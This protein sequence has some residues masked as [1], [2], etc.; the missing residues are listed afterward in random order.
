MVAEHLETCR[1][2]GLEAS[3]YTA[4]KTAITASGPDGAPVD[5]EAVQRLRQFARD[6]SEPPRP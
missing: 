6:L 5:D 3:A 4:I 2:C 1:R